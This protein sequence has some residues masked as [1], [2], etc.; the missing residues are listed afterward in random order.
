MLLEYPINI[1]NVGGKK[2]LNLIRLSVDNT[3]KQLNQKVVSFNNDGYSLFIRFKPNE[4]PTINPQ[5]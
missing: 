1:L 3:S 5:F 4:T 2:V